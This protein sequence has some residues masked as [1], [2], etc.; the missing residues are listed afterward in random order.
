MAANHLLDSEEEGLQA[1]TL[2]G[3]SHAPI[4]SSLI[5]ISSLCII[6]IIIMQ[7]ALHAQR[8]IKQS[9][10]LSVVCCP[11]VVCCL[12]SVVRTKITRS[13]HLGVSSDS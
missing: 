10:C 7:H 6:N 12:L 2:G 11:S 3:H 1:H 5:K 9:I 4:I 8:G 13:Q